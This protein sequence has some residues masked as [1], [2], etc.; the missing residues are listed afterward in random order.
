[1]D[2]EAKKVKYNLKFSTFKF[3][4]FPGTNWITYWDGQTKTDYDMFLSMLSYFDKNSR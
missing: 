2:N 4:K 1:M 3:D